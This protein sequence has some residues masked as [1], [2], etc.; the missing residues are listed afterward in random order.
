MDPCPFLVRKRDD[1]EP[2]CSVGVN[3]AYVGRDRALC[4]TCPLAALPHVRECE[5]ADIYITLRRDKATRPEMQLYVDCLAPEG[6]A[7]E[8][9]CSECPAW[10]SDG[11]LVEQQPQ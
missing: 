9:R 3:F 10:H 6:V 1:A 4:R 8:A 11:W 5:F 7:M 2:R